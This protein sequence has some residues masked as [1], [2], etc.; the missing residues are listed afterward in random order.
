MTTHA[1]MDHC[2]NM[3]GAYLDYPFGPQLAA[4]RVGKTADKSGR[5]FAQ[6]FSLKGIDVVTFSCD[7]LTG[8]FYKDLYPDVLMPAYHCPE[9]QRKY[10][11]TLPVDKLPDEVMREMAYS[12]YNTVIRKLPKYIRDTL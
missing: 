7:V 8:Q 3:N 5:I 10:A 1:L 12:S 2:L 11:Y 4:V 6:F 9:F